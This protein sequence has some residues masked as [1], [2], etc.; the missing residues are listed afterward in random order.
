MMT[1]L[2]IKAMQDSSLFKAVVL[3][4]S[5]SNTTYIL[6][7]SLLALYQDFTVNPSEIVLSLDVSLSDANTTQL[8]ADQVIT[9]RVPAKEDNPYSGVVAANQAMSNALVAMTQFV[10]SHLSNS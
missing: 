1:P 4:P 2:I 3:G 8:M 5:L 9:E 10:A 6:N 7:A